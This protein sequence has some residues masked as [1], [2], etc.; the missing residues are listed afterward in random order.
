MRLDTEDERQ[1]EESQAYPSPSA[2][3]VQQ[4]VEGDE[5]QEPPTGESEVE[6]RED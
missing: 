1:D 5:S 3:A 6:P 2:P 4:P